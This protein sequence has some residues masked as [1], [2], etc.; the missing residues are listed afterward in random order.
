M[1]TKK[2]TQKPTE[3]TK[4]RSNLT[5]KCMSGN[6]PKPD[7]ENKEPVPKK[8]VV[9]KDWLNDKFME[10]FGNNKK[11][12]KVRYKNYNDYLKSN[13]WIQIKDYFYKHYEGHR[14]VCEVTGKVFEKD[15]LKNLHLHHFRYPKDWDNDSHKN[16]ILICKDVHDFIHNIMNDYKHEKYKENRETYK[17]YVISNYWYNELEKIDVDK[18]F[19]LK[20]LKDVENKKIKDLEKTNKRLKLM[21]RLSLDR[22]IEISEVE[23]NELA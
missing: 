10:S 4:T 9:D 23:K 16:L 1:T 20:E 15:E 12:G 21:L 14:N 3:E 19:S 2:T 17:S 8:A 5:V 13:L 18:F 22:I 11:T 6:M 7:M